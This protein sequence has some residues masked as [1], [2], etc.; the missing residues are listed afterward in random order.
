[1]YVPLLNVP[2]R[3]V[4][5]GIV[6]RFSVRIRPSSRFVLLKPFGRPAGRPYSTIPLFLGEERLARPTQERKHAYLVK[7]EGARVII[8]SCVFFLFFF[9]TPNP[10]FRILASPKSEFLSIQ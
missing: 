5:Q 3:H 9:L 8:P 2:L 6:F 4:C 10:L 1:M 7:S